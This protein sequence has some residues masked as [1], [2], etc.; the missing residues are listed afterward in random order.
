MVEDSPLGGKSFG[1]VSIDIECKNISISGDIGGGS[2]CLPNSTNSGNRKC[3]ILVFPEPLTGS[4]M[5]QN[6]TMK[7]SPK[8]H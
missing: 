6:K 1:F 7:F 5:N 4:E 3:F 8:T 2:Y